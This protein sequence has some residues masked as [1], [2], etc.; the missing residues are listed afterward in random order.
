M[1]PAVKILVQ[2]HRVIESMLRCLERLIE[3]SDRDN[4]LDGEKART[5][6]SFF[7]E[8]ADA[9]H[10]GKEEDILFKFA[11]SKTGG[12]G[13]VEVLKEEHVEGRGYVKN[14][15]RNIDK[16]AAGDPDVITLFSENGRDLIDMLRRHI[17]REDEVVFPM[18]EE[19]CRSED[20]EK[21]WTQ[22][23]AVEKDAGGDRHQRFIDSARSCCKHFNVPFT[24]TNIPDILVRFA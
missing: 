14:M 20:A 5:L 10:H 16:A 7:R 23:V 11:E 18:I 19:P 13:P 24:E 4:K 3:N 6:I 9:C 2:E 8:F 12:Q 17:E 22:F 21:I 15:I 1:I